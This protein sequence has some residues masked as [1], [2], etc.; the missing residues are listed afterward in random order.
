MAEIKAL[1]FTDGQSVTP[2]SGASN[3]FAKNNFSATTNPSATDDS[4]S[5]YSVGSK[6]INVTTDDAYICVDSTASAAIWKITVPAAVSLTVETKTANYTTDND[7]G[8]ILVDAISNDITITLNTAVGNTGQQLYIKRI[9]DT[10]IKTDT[11]VDG[12]VTVGTENINVASHPLTDLQRVQ[13]TS[14]GTLPSGLA[15]ATDYY[16]IYVDSNNIKLASSRANAVADTAVDIVSAAGGGTHTI[17]S[18]VNDVIVDGNSS[19]T[20]DS[21]LTIDI[22]KQYV[23]LYIVSDNTNWNVIGIKPKIVSMVSVHTANGHGSTDATIRR[24]GTTLV[25]TGSDITYN[26]SATLGA[27]FI[28]N[29]DGVYA[30]HYSDIF[31]VIS[32]YGISLNSTQRTVDISTITVADRIILEDNTSGGFVSGLGATKFLSKGDIIRPHTSGGV[33]H[34]STEKT[35][36]SIVKVS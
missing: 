32:T 10:Q 30:M 33:D 28:I 1:Q 25:D 22:N 7:D 21:D 31:N 11:F 20:I 17:T 9:D 18:E 35:A 5:S 2:P 29:E 27:T 34:A 26:D 13:L 3:Y 15:L 16:V 23:S 24:F 14:S 6:W 19:E 36:F 8:L 4:A 12:D